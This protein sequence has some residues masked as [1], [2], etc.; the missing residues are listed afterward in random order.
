MYNAHP[1]FWPGQA[2]IWPCIALPRSTCLDVAGVLAL[3]VATEHCH[4]ASLSTLASIGCCRQTSSGS[5]SLT[6]ECVVI[7]FHG[8]R[9]ANMQCTPSVGCSIWP[10]YNVHSYFYINILVKKAHYSRSFTVFTESWH[11]LWMKRFLLLF[12]LFS[13]SSIYVDVPV[14][15]YFKCNVFEWRPAIALYQQTITAV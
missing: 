5:E 15:C 12:V 13:S 7:R 6:D 14:L 2:C 8:G 11:L 4:C 10:V 1:D 3:S 9:L